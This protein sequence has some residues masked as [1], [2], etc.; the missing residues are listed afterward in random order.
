MSEEFLKL[1]DKVDR[2]AR[3]AR[4]QDLSLLLAQSDAER[5]TRI[6]AV[7]Q[8]LDAGTYLIGSGPY[9]QGVYSVMVDEVVLGRL[10]TPLEEPLDKPVISSARMFPVLPL[11]R[12]RAITRSSRASGILKSIT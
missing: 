12:C 11:V 1:A 2:L 10:A 4:L 8:G 5:I 6:A 3:T 7:F 9:T